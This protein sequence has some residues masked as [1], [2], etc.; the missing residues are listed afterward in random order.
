MLIRCDFITNPASGDVQSESPWAKVGSDYLVVGIVA[1]AGAPSHL[2]IVDDSGEPSLWPMAMFTVIDG[3]LPPEWE[4]HGRAGALV[5][6]PREFLSDDYWERYWDG[7]KEERRL[8]HEFVESAIATRERGEVDIAATRD[9]LVLLASSLNEALEAV[10]GWE[11]D[12]RLGG[13]PDEARALR[14]KIKNLLRETRK[15]D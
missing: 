10:E 6:E 13:S 15:P 1:G 11:F 5:I 14:S 2:R 8:F 9:E 4:A 12:T 3:Q 7:G